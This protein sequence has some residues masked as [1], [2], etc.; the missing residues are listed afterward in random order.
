[1]NGMLPAVFI[2]TRTGRIVKEGCQSC[3]ATMTMD[4]EWYRAIRVGNVYI[5]IPEKDL[6]R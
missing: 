6:P 1:M 5:Y 3:G 4:E 2:D